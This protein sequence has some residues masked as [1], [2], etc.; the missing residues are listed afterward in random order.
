MSFPYKNVLVLGATSG[1]GLALAE[2]MIEHGI[3][4]IAVGRRQENL[5]S[6]HQKHGKEKVSTIQF[7]VTDLAGIPSFVET[8]T[9]SHPNLDSIFM[10]SG[11]QR[12]IDF[13]HPSTIDLDLITTELT[14]NYT[15]TI[16][17]IKYFLPHLQ[18]HPSTPTS[19][20]FTTSGLALVPILR[21]PNYCASKAAMHHLIL[22]LRAQL[23][24]AEASK[25][26]RVIEILP[27]AVQ[28]ELHDQKHQPD[29]KDGGA[30]G[31]PL[32]AFVDEA[33]EGLSKG[34]EDVPVGMVKGSY[35]AFENERR[36]MFEGITKRLGG[37][38]EE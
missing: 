23:S 4:I 22:T 3:H 16:H 26:V 17:L 13:T 32:G 14:T 27:P 7:D 36:S 20:I 24:Y 1:I 15:S 6:L 37:W 5:S 18:S 30:F 8:V 33:W 10:N 35:G 9:K 28:T 25:N 21:C 34:Q 19:L 31:M 2:R 38:V 12:K 29:I 11:I